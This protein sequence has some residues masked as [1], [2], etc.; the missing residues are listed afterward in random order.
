MATFITAGEAPYGSHY[1]YLSKKFTAKAGASLRARTVG[2]T[3]YQVYLN[4]RRV[5][6]GPISGP[7]HIRFFDELTLD[8]YLVEGE[9]EI[10]VKLL[11]V[12]ADFFLVTAHDYQPLF[13]FDGLLTDEDGERALVTDESWRIERDDSVKLFYPP[14]AMKTVAP[15]EEHFSE[16]TLTE[17]K[18]RVI[19]ENFDLRNQYGLCDGAVRRVLEPRSIPEMHEGEPVALTKVDRGERYIELDAG[20]YTTAKV[21]ICV[22]L[23]KGKTLK[24]IYAECYMIP[25]DAYHGIKDRRDR[26]TSPDS[27]ITG[28]C[29]IIH[30]T[31]EPFT[32]DTFWYRAFRFIRLE[33]DGDFELVS[34][35]YRPY[36]YPLSNEGTFRSNDEQL[37][38]MWDIGRNTLLSCMH[39][40]IVDCPYYE[41]QQYDMDSA[42]ETL[43][44]YRLSPDA[45]LVKKTILD[46]AA[47]Q[48]EDGMLQANYPS[49]SR[50]VIPNFSLYWIFMLENYLLYTADFSI[51]K[52]TSGVLDRILAAFDARLGERGLVTP[53]TEYWHFI[54]WVPEWRIGIPS[55]GND[56]PICVDSFM[57]AAALKSAARIFESVGNSY[58]KEE[59]LERA[60]RVNKDA[61]SAF[62]D[63][64][65]GYF[66]DTENHENMSQHTAVWAVLSEAVTEDE[67]KQLLERAM[68]ERMGKCSFSFGFYLFRALEKAGLYGKYAGKLLDGWRRMVDLGCTSW[69]ENPDSP[70]SECHGWSSA[71]TYEL[72]AVA[73][74]VKPTS[75]G[76]KTLTIEP[77]PE[78]FGITEATL[79][80]P[81]PYGVV[82][83]ELNE[84]EISVTLPS[85][86]MTATVNIFGNSYSMIGKKKQIFRK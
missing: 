75:P 13:S 32:L 18:A 44:S 64:R 30:G 22:K 17:L 63:E 86:E 78:Y 47:S 41:Q 5:C 29:D 12:E 28:R 71:P 2:A 45:R 15:Y 76:Y 59:Y 25:T 1:Y 10:K 84:R 67:A 85:S 23:P 69:A 83:L 16:K 9:N 55:F 14:E 77:H 54:D 43:Y 53:S 81:T 80:T 52:K 58:R 20:A 38:K 50:Q 42:L 73:L 4:G 68:T 56:E 21:N 36:H 6:E 3:R 19:L 8:E 66:R 39:E 31:G 40:V 7:T 79:T 65:L 72:S 33:C 49:R 60:E 26:K 24:V 48:I 37:T 62:F 11:Y 35:T 74:G 82:T 51:L 57:Y 61:L 34:A 70:R 27:I 46:L